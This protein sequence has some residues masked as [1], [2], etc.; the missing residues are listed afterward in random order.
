[1]KG[2]ECGMYPSFQPDDDVNRLCYSKSLF[3]NT[4]VF[5][6]LTAISWLGKKC[7]QSNRVG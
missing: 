6:Q 3:D 5:L 2:L 7:H 4:W 1:M